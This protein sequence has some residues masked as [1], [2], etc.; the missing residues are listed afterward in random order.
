MSDLICDVITRCVWSCDR[1]LVKSVYM[2]NLDRRVHYNGYNRNWK[3]QK[4]ENIDINF[5]INL[6]LIDGLRIAFASVSANDSHVLY[7]LLPDSNDCSYSLYVMIVWSP[8]GVTTE[9]FFAFTTSVI[10]VTSAQS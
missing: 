3:P 9:T 6:H 1:L 7:N 2:L 4:R 8:L 10:F 5:Y